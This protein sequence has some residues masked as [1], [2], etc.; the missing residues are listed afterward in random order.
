MESPNVLLSELRFIAN[1]WVFIHT[2]C[3][4]GICICILQ[5]IHW[6]NKHLLSTYIMPNTMLG[7]EHPKK[8]SNVLTGQKGQLIFKY[9]WYWPT[10]QIET[11]VRH[12]NAIKMRLTRSWRAS[13]RRWFLRQVLAE[14]SR[15]LQTNPNSGGQSRNRRKDCSRVQRSKREWCDL[16]VIKARTQG[17][18]GMGREKTE[19]GLVCHMKATGQGK[20]YR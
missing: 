7:T 14:K 19:K 18:L 16:G 17:P 6:F 4:Y 13:Q 11:G 5:F 10:F 15:A 2:H 3:S 12:Y 8:E 1:P 9:A 20:K